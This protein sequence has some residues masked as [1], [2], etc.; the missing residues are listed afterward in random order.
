M[1]S[2]LICFFLILISTSCMKDQACTAA[3][4]ATEESKIQDFFIAN[5]M[6]AT[7]HSSGIYFEIMAPGFGIAP[8][9]GSEITVGYVG[10]FLNGTI[11]DQNSRIKNH[12]NNF[13]EGW[14][15]GIP[16]IKK[17]GT[18]RLVI[19]SAYAYG[20]TSYGNIPANSVLY[21]EINLIDVQ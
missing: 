14:K 13:I 15:L 17:G 12:L 18:I 1:K 19:P 4:P 10:K 21:F 8:T 20:C 7:K 11:F 3:A 5:S 2:I 16:L 6:A 9:S